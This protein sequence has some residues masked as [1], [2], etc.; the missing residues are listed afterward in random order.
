MGLF[1][2]RNKI[3]NYPHEVKRKDWENVLDALYKRT[4]ASSAGGIAVISNTDRE[5]PGD[6]VGALEKELTYRIKPKRAD[7]VS[8]RL[9]KIDSDNFYKIF[10]NSTEGAQKTQ[11][12]YRLKNIL[13][14][15]IMVYPLM[16]GVASKGLLVFDFP[17]EERQMQ[18]VLLGIKNELDQ[19]EIPSAPRPPE[20][21]EKDEKEGE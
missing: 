19:K 17:L 21:D 10:K 16:C 20:A 4:I 11:D 1:S 15:E 7:E 12:F 13:R 9:R 3:G 18:K 14:D 2:K 8:A 5:Y 6:G